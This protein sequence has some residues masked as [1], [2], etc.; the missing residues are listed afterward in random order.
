LVSEIVMSNKKRINFKEMLKTTSGL[1][2]Y[3]QEISSYKLDS[4]WIRIEGIAEIAIAV[5][6]KPVNDSKKK[7]L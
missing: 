2:K 5:M 4:T 1:K 6:Q 3:I 7:Q